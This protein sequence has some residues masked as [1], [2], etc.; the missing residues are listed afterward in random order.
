MK[1]YPI[2]E[3][4]LIRRRVNIIKLIIISIIEKPE[5]D[6]KIT[7]KSGFDRE[8]NLDAQNFQ[9]SKKKPVNAP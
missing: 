3:M 8:V 1:S 7:F 9:R 4:H 2:G 6:M 5:I